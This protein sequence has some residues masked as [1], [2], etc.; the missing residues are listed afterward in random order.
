MRHLPDL[1]CQW[2]VALDLH[3]EPEVWTSVLTA[4]AEGT[5]RLIRIRPWRRSLRGDA[6]VA[7]LARFVIDGYELWYRYLDETQVRMIELGRAWRRDAQ[8]TLRP[9]HGFTVFQAFTANEVGVLLQGNFG[10]DAQALRPARARRVTQ[11]ARG[12]RSPR[13]SSDRPPS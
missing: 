11:T 12:R 7:W 9:R 1:D 2:L 5:G 6:Q 4:L 10:G 8:G 3:R 13:T